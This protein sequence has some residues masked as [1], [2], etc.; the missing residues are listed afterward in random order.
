MTEDDDPVTLWISE[1]QDGDPEAANKIWCHFF[2]R[3]QTIARHKLSTNTRAA[4]DEEDAV[5]SAFISFCDG[6]SNGNFPFL[7]NRNELWRLLLVIT[8]RKVA[9]RHR[10][11]LQDCRD[12]RRVLNDFVFQG[13]EDRLLRVATREPTPEFAAE[14]E[15][16]CE[17]MLARLP[18]DEMRQ[19]ALLKL[20]G[21]SDAEVGT[22]LG[23][24]RRTVQRRLEIVRRNW[25]KQ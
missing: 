17:V 24:S 1:L 12:V 25:L 22:R 14:F 15:D 20:E 8:T 7:K 16:T 13:N 11:E 9:H 18:S 6:V 23:C 4:Y 21:L 5:Q 2:Q 19:I 3:L 10:S